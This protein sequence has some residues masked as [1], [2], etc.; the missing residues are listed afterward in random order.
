MR[1][2]NYLLKIK[3]H[4]CFNISKTRVPIGESL[5]DRQR[6]IECR[7]CKVKE[8]SIK[9]TDVDNFFYRFKKFTNLER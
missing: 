3:C 5:D 8:T 1:A 9:I 4:N 7:Y 6:T 2:K